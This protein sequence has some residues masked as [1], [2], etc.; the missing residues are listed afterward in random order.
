M[1]KIKLFLLTC[2]LTATLGMNLS[3]ADGLSALSISQCVVED[4]NIHIYF[5]ISDEKGEQMPI[6][7]ENIQFT[8]KSIIGEEAPPCEIASIDQYDKSAEGTGYVLLVDV[9]DSVKNFS[10]MKTAMQDFINALGPKDNVAV[11]T[12]GDSVSLVQEFT[13]DKVKL[14][15]AIGDLKANEDWTKLYTGLISAQNY[16]RGTYSLVSDRRTVVLFSDGYDYNSG[17]DTKMDVITELRRSKAYPIYALQFDPGVDEEKKTMVEN[18]GDIVDMSHGEFMTLAGSSIKV[19][20]ENIFKDIEK[21][22][23]AVLGANLE[24]GKYT[25]EVKTTVPQGEIYDEI[26]INLSKDITAEIP[27]TTTTEEEVTTEAV[28]DTG[29]STEEVTTEGSQAEETSDDVATVDQAQVDTKKDTTN[30]ILLIIMAVFT[31]LIV[32]LIIALVASKK[33][34][35]TKPPITLSR[36]TETKAI[37]LKPFHSNNFNP[38]VH[39]LGAQTILGKNSK[40]ADIFIDYDPLVL[41]EHLILSVMNGYVYISKAVPKADL[42]INGLPVDSKRELR[43][44]DII[45]FADIEMVITF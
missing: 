43:T 4:N 8:I 39:N 14:E 34:H 44:G 29:A 3:Y 17:G 13:N 23:I 45:S 19:C 33:Q 11:M 30:L 42:F 27:E 20:Y 10:E 5:D 32:I 16:C 36:D 28:I 7:A 21:E 26:E 1:K 40:K 31:V 25:I 41:D 35:V 2:I 15:K 22:Y 37:T 24:A 6:K 12:F 38:I 9:S 18:L